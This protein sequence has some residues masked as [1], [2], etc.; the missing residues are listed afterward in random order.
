M[1]FNLSDDGEALDGVLS[2]FGNDRAAL[3]DLLLAVG[4]VFVFFFG[5]VRFLHGKRRTFFCAFHAAALLLN[6]MRLVFTENAE[7]YAEQT[8]THIS[9]ARFYVS[10]K[11]KAQTCPPMSCK[12]IVCT[13]CRV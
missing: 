2:V 7:S 5:F 1:P 6:K 13:F 3:A 11:G 8:F 10:C 9:I 12:Y 4:K